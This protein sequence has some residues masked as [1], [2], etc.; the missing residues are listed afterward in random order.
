[1]PA[2]GVC[3]DTLY[4]V[5]VRVCV[6]RGL[7]CTLLG[8]QCIYLSLSLSLSLSHSHSLSLSHSL[9]LSLPLHIYIHIDVSLCVYMYMYIYIY[10]RIQGV[11]VCKRTTCRPRTRGLSDGDARRRVITGRERDTT[12]ERNE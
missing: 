12:S 1:M 7:L 4:N 3:T 9:Y 6:S 2:D 5:V 11:R 10:I 8:H